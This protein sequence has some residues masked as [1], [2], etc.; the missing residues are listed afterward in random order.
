MI[1]DISVAVIAI[2][3]VV[4]VLYF[5]TLI[6]ALRMTMG[7]VNQTL[8][9]TRKQLSEVGEQAQKAVEHTNQ[10]SVD[11]KQKVAAL[12]PIFN[13]VSHVGEILEHKSL[14]L[15]KEAFASMPEE[16]HLSSVESEE[17]K[18]ISERGLI[19]VAA[20]LELAS[21]GLRLWQKTKKR[22]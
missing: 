6:K 12:T 8:V 22:R 11:F 2:A 20:I 1:I 17:K 14:T 10:L 5:I 18:K 19:T 21:I 9:E 3:F 4:L 16:S 15:K 13:A 7:Q